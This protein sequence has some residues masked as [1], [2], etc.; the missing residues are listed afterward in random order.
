MCFLI[1]YDVITPVSVY[2]VEHVVEFYRTFREMIKT[3]VFFKILWCHSPSISSMFDFLVRKANKDTI[4]WSGSPLLGT[5]DSKCKA[6]GECVMCRCV[7]EHTAW[8]RPQSV[9]ACTTTVPC[10][11]SC[12]VFPI[13]PLSASAYFREGR[14]PG[15]IEWYC[16]DVSEQV[17]VILL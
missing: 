11:Y 10:V 9:K 1:I 4:G 12:V 3:F 14:W 13:T 5:L 17:F 8:F 15:V 2:T 6:F 16:S 7:W